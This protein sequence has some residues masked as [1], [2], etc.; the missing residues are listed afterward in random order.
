MLP[1]SEISF[2]ASL[3]ISSLSEFA[4]SIIFIALRSL[5]AFFPV[6][7]SSI[8]TSM[9]TSSNV[10][11]LPCHLTLAFICSCSASEGGSLGVHA[12]L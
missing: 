7:L 3:R 8:R 12:L 6:T 2:F 5:S 9:A 4:S 10:F 11:K 1:Y